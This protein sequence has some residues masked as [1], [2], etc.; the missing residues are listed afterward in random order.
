VDS[1]V[2]CCHFSVA[3][4]ITCRID[5]LSGKR[6]LW[7]IATIVGSIAAVLALLPIKELHPFFDLFLLGVPLWVVLLAIVLAIS[8]PGLVRKRYGPKPPPIPER[9]PTPDEEAYRLKKTCNLTIRVWKRIDRERPN[10]YLLSGNYDNWPPRGKSV[11]LIT[12]LIDANKSMYW[13]Q[14]EVSASATEKTWSGRVG[15]GPAAYEGEEMRAILAIVGACGEVLCKYYMDA[16][17]SKRP[18]HKLPLPKLPDDVIPCQDVTL[19]KEQ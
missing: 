13:P 4:S 6:R 10:Q 11:W 16:T 5:N 14:G 1:A 7:L 19:A 9:P 3:R 18:G 15:L 2:R 17:D 8:L 12:T